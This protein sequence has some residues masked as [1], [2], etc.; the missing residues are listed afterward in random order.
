M[1]KS[2]LEPTPNMQFI[3]ALLHPGLG[4]VQ[5]PNDRG[6]KIQK[7]VHYALMEELVFHQWQSI[8][9]LLTKAQDLTLWEK[10]HFQ[11]LQMFL[12]RHR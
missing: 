1:G 7:A 10:L 12:L 8:I 6:M 3:D 9:G 4:L 11:H 5:I 2:Q